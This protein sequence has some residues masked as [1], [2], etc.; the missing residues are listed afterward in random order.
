MAAIPSCASI[1][2]ASFSVMLRARSLFDLLLPR[3]G[4]TVDLK[5]RAAQ[6]VKAKSVDV[7]FPGE[8][9]IDRKIVELDYLLDRNPAAAHGLDNGRLTSYRPAL[10]QRRQLRHGAECVCIIC[11]CC[12][13]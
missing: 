5:A 9:L 11:R 3:F 4:I 2:N 1:V 10:P 13:P 12:I 7:A 6:P 8:K